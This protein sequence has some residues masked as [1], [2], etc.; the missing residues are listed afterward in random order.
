[1]FKLLNGLLI[2]IALI[3]IA[4]A[5]AVV[6]SIYFDGFGAIPKWAT[7]S[8]TSLLLFSL[9]VGVA[10]KLMKVKNEFNLVK[11]SLVCYVP[12][13]GVAFILGF[14]KQVGR[15]AS[16]DI[17]TNMMIG[18]IEALPIFTEVIMSFCALMASNVVWS[19]YKQYQNNKIELGV[20]NA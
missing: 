6:A 19:A 8:S 12:F 15:S 17:A 16:N 11:S 9:G 4:L 10:A 2:Y 5:F 18:M 7:I 1:M 14:D 3:F 13:T 20:K